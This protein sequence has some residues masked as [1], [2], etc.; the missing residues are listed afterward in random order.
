MKLISLLVAAAFAFAANTA[1]AAET[2]GVSGSDLK[3]EKKAHKHHK[4]PK[5]HKAKKAAN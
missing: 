2:N 3:V 1:F 4:H 5:H